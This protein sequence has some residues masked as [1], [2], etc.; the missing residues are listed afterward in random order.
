KQ[1]IFDK[2]QH[3]EWS[4]RTVRTI[5]EERPFFRNIDPTEEAVGNAGRSVEEGKNHGYLATGFSALHG[6]RLNA[7]QN[8]SLSPLR[9]GQ[10]QPRMLHQQIIQS[11]M[12]VRSTNVLSRVCHSLE[13]LPRQIRECFRLQLVS[14][15]YRLRVGRKLPRPFRNRK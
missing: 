10:E 3:P 8:R 2:R 9:G 1:C 4:G 7:V 6:A 12:S 5:G 13:Q 14:L 11:A 15:Q